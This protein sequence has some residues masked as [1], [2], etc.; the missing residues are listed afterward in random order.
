VLLKIYSEKE[1]TGA[2]LES[3]QDEVSEALEKAGYRL[4]SL[5]AEPL[6]L[7]DE[8]E[9]NTADFSQPMSYAPSVYKGVDYR[10]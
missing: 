6:I 7:P 3:R 4:L 2:F 10:V 5:K 8:A 1:A 9:G